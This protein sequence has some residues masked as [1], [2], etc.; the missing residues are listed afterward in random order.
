MIKRKPIVSQKKINPRDF[1]DLDKNLE[2]IF[3]IIF[4]TNFYL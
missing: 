4:F 3:Q 2:G 1:Y